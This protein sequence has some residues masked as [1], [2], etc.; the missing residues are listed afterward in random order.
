MALH[1][2]IEDGHWS[3]AARLQATHRAKSQFTVRG[4]LSR[5]DSGGLADGGEQLVRAV[6]VTGRARADDAGM[7]SARLQGEE[8]IEGGH[9]VHPAGRQLQ[10]VGNEMKKGRLQEAEQ[11]L[12]GVQHFDERVLPILMT[13]HGRF[14]LLET[15]VVPRRRER[16]WYLP[17]HLDD[18]KLSFPISGWQ[19]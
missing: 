1:H 16:G 17:S 11:L 3:D 12:G 4:G 10:L 13:L 5:L 14:E 2:A 15:R 6:D 9:A 7:S 18:D 8:M 19:S